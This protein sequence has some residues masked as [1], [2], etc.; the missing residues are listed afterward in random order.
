[1]S[2]LISIKEAAELL[3]VS[4]KTLRRWDDEGI[5]KSI[6]THGGHRRYNQD[7]IDKYMQV[8]VEKQDQN[9]LSLPIPECH[10]TSRKQKVIWT[11]RAIV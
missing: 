4:T 2:K 7:D 6:K 1:M 5:L 10:H 11:V 9:D 8:Y 3:S